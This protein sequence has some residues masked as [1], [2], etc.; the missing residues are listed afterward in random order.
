MSSITFADHPEPHADLLDLLCERAAAGLSEPDEQRLHALLLSA[1]ADAVTW[2][3]DAFEAPA[4]AAALAFASDAAFAGEAT[5]GSKAPFGVDAPPPALHRR[6]AAAAEAFI[7]GPTADAAP[8]AS[9]TVSPTATRPPAQDTPTGPALRLAGAGDHA[10]AA[11]PRAAS[12]FFAWT[13]WVAA[14]ACV[15]VAALAVQRLPNRLQAA[16]RA[17]ATA[18]DAVRAP[19]L[20]VDQVD[21]LKAMGVTQR[22]P[23][24]TGVTGEAA[25]SDAA[26]AGLLTIAGLAPNNPAEFQY[27]LWIFD[28]AR[29]A[30]E[31]YADWPGILAQYPVDGGVF[32]FTPG[33]DGIARIPVNPKIPVTNAAIFAITKEPPGGVVVSDREVVFL[34]AFPAKS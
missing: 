8:V 9:P 32:N 7:A 29:P 6:L 14:A 25:W 31:Q 27:Q 23:L 20:H 10:P 1:D 21:A 11:A 19:W 2:S 5:F 18:A 16:D 24:D 22:H 28:A 3:L 4:A 30:G 12:A 13:G 34:A 15:A 26:N 33:P 17:L